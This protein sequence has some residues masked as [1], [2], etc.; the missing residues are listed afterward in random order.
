MVFS[1]MDN[2]NVLTKNPEQFKG[3]GKFVSRVFFAS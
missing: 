3:I 2:I 1:E